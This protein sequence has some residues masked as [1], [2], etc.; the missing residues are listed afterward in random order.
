MS[1]ELWIAI[2]GAVTAIAGAFRWLLAFYFKQAGIIEDLRNKNEVAI[3]AGFTRAIDNLKAEI[4]LHK[5][6]IKRSTD[7][8]K[9][10]ESKLVKNTD[11]GQAIMK[12]LNLFVEGTEL[13]MKK[14]E[15]QVV[16]LANGLL[17]VKGGLNGGTKGDS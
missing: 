1:T 2:F 6:L 13:R 7:Q 4:A 9:T 15:N 5:D 10:I 14:F 16:Q 11:D 12:A 8:I 17:L 3:L